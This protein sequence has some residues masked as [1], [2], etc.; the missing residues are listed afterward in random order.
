[1]P[2]APPGPQ[3]S[4]APSAAVPQQSFRERAIA[5]LGQESAPER[6]QPTERQNPTP[7]A[8]T[9]SRDVGSAQDLEQDPQGFQADDEYEEEGQGG[10][11]EDPEG[12][13]SDDTLEA[14][15]QEGGEWEKRYK[16]LQAEYT[17]LA[18]ERGE[19]ASEHAEAMGET[20]RLK[21]D[22]EDRF[23]EAVGRAEYFANV[24]SGHANQFR[25]IN[26]TQVP[27]DQVANLQQRAQQALAMEQQ[28]TAAWDEVKKRKDETLT[29]VKQREAE[30]AK[31]RLKRTIPNWGNET[32]AQLRQHAAQRGMDVK[33]FNGITN[34]VIIE[35]LYAQMVLGN[36]GN[37]VLTKNKRKA[38]VPGGRQ[39]Q[40]QPRD[41]R[42]KFER[43]QV[44]PNQRG[45]FAEKTRHRLALERQ[46]R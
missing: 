9:P 20:L 27:P 15:P 43:A 14:S 1:M 29:H 13:P 38:Q 22:L 44:V 12:T 11:Y 8:R 33:E 4:G 46:G 34:P 24:M 19:I 21:F 40:Q 2:I 25:N 31:V 6:P 42:G 18:Q 41:S 16:D 5:R 39:P 7:E 10:L 32:Y 37:K 26:W 45:S 23:E 30:I 35:A 17:Q 28:A 3:T 36:A